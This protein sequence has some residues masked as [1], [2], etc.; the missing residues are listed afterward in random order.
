[1]SLKEEYLDIFKS[2]ITYLENKKDIDKNIV[3]DLELVTY[4]D[5]EKNNL[6]GTI[7]KPQTTYGYNNLK[8]W[9][10]FY[11]TDEI[12]L[13]ESQILYKNYDILSITIIM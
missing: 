4:K 13:K 2:P 5:D 6:Y 7:L 12:F 9:S 1:M 3:D 8:S 11:T 10:E